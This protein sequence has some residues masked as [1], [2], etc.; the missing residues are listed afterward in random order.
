MPFGRYAGAIAP[1]MSM[2]TPAVSVDCTLPT[3]YNIS[4]S[5]GPSN[6]TAAASRA[7]GAGGDRIVANRYI[8]RSGFAN[9]I[10]V[11]VIY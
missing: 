3:A 11:T 10:T 1:S 5:A 7:L 9:T 8:G 2:S 6:S 4:V